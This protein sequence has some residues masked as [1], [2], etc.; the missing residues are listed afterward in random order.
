[1]RFETATLKPKYGGL[2][3]VIRTR[4]GYTGGEYNTPSYYDMKDHSE[5]V[6]ID[7]DPTVISFEE[8]LNIFWSSHS[9]THIHFRKQ[10]MSAIWFHNEQQKEV[11]LKTFS[12]QPQKVFTV[13]EPFKFWT[14]AEFYHQKYRLQK[15]KKILSFFDEM[16]EDEFIK[17]TFITKLNAFLGG[18]TNIQ[19][20]EQLSSSE[21]NVDKKKLLESLKSL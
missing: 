12:Q 21:E 5:S 10:Y 3:G 6:Q 19:E 20:I 13:I 8:L 7:F 1:M 9:P 4:V 17:S 2:K 11:A 15:K 14:N 16:D 18:Y